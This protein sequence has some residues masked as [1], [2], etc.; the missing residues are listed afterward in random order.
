MLL[1]QV[2]IRQVLR[3]TG[4]LGVLH[5]RVRFEHGRGYAITYHPA[6]AMR[7]PEIAA[8]MREDFARFRELI[9]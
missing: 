6:A 4:P 2:A 3:E 8:Q 5:G 1:G 9:T 7:F